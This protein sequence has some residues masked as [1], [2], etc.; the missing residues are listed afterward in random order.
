[1]SSHQGPLLIRELRVVHEGQQQQ[2]L[3]AHGVCRWHREA[4]GPADHGVL[5]DLSVGPSSYII[6][7]ISISISIVG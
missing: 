3:G 1:M 6:S 4:V 7:I 2:W 5:A